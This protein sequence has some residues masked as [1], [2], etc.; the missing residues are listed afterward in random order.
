MEKFSAPQN[1]VVDATIH[2]L[3]QVEELEQRLETAD[4]EGSTTVETTPTGTTCSATLTC[5]F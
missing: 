4:W 1:R 5:K 3:F 2:N